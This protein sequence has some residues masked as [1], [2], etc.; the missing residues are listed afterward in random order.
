MGC[1]GSRTKEEVE[2]TEKH[3]A[4]ATYEGCLNTAGKRD[5]VGT[6]TWTET[7]LNLWKETW[8]MQ[9]HEEV[10]EIAASSHRG[11]GSANYNGEWKD[12]LMHGVGVFT[13]DGSRYEGEWRNGVKHGR[14]KQQDFGALTYDGEWWNG[15]R[16]GLGEQ[17]CNA[18]T[19]EFRLRRLQI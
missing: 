14:G 10:V 3:V 5:G 11:D 6:A 2:Q 9:T 1:K 18:Y 16:W 13:M 7:W 17:S 15:Q 4:T 12:G 8:P 19:G